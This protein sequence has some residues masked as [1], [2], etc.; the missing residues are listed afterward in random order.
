MDLYTFWY[1]EEKG[2]GE[3]FDFFGTGDGYTNGYGR[4]VNSW[5]EYEKN[6]NWKLDATGNYTPVVE[7]LIHFTGKQGTYPEGMNWLYA[8]YYLYHSTN[9]WDYI[10]G[11]F[12]TQWDTVTT[13][14]GGPKPIMSKGQ[15]YAMHFPFNSL[16][17]KHDPDQ[18][19]DYWTGKYILV[20][21]TTG[22]HVISGK[23]KAVNQIENLTLNPETAVLQGNA[24]FAEIAPSTSNAIWALEQ[25][26]T[27]LSPA[28]GALVSNFTE[29]VG[30]RAIGVHYETGRVIYDSIPQEE[31]EQEIPTS[32]PTI[33]DGLSLVVETIDGGLRIT[34]A[35][36]QQVLLYNAAGQLI[37]NQYLTSTKEVLLPAGVYIIPTGTQQPKRVVVF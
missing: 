7:K 1:Y 34:P 22:P 5:M 28:Q 24:S 16:N 21:S 31:P 27:T 2:I 37:L 32:I 23:D 30:L 12:T 29:P 26:E 17:G 25:K 6:A 8:N 14:L 15:T 4:F 3:A 18:T 19:W 10:N 20:E 13:P 11:K 33:M 9:E 36:A 35:Q